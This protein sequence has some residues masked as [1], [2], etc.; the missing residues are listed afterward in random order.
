MYQAGWL[1]T[2][3]HYHLHQVLHALGLR[4]WY[5]DCIELPVFNEV[6]TGGLPA[7]II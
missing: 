1:T 5:R 4:D 2:L 7:G 6:G 3:P